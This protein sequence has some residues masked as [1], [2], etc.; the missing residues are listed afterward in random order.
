VQVIK[1]RNDKDKIIEM[2]EKIV[3]GKKEDIDAH[4]AQAQRSKHINTDYVERRNGKFRLR[5]ARLIRKTLCFS[6]KAVFHDA[7]ISSTAQIFNYCQPVEA[8]KRC[9]NPIAVRFE[10]KYEQI[11]AAMAEGLIDKILTIRELLCIRPRII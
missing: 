2:G 7:M 5:C 11:S 1:K 6:K 4:Y 9:I 3:Y 8:L 10:Q